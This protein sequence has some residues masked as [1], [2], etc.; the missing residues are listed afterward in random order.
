MAYVAPVKSRQTGEITSYRVRWRT[1]GARDGDPQGERFVDVDAAEVFK[2]AVDAAGQQWPPGWVKGKGLI[3][4]EDEDEARFVFEAYALE[5]IK[6]RT[7]AEDYYRGAIEK[8]LRTYILPTFANCDVRSTTHFSRRTVQGWVAT[9]KETKV[10][11]GSEHKP[12]SPKTLKNLHGLL[13]SILKEA[14]LEEPPLRLRNPCDLVDLPRT[15]DGGVADDGTDEDMCFLE[16]DEVQ[17]I[18]DELDRPTDKRLVR[19]KYATGLRWGE[20]TALP[21]RNVFRDP[22]DGKAK[23]RV[24]RAWKRKRGG[25]YYLGTPKSKRSRR[26]VRLDEVTYAEFLEDGLDEGS[27]TDL[28]HVNH[29]G[30]R[31][32]YSTFY[33]RFKVAVVRAHEAGRLPREKHPTLHDLRHSHAAALLSAGRGLTYVQRRLGHESITTTSDRYGHLLPVADDDAMATIVATLG[34]P[35]GL[36][37]E[38]D[39]EEV[40]YGFSERAAS[41]NGRRVYAV[42]MG[43]H[44]EGFWDVED[45]KAVAGQWLLDKGE[46]AL[47]EAWSAEW[48]KRSAPTGKV[49]GLRMVR[50]HVPERLQLW[51]VGPAMY[52]AD[53]TERVVRPEDHE[54]R[55]V[56][57]WEW[58]EP[59]TD[60]AAE[61]RVE[62]LPSGETVASVWGL[63][64]ETALG[65]YAQARSDALRVCGMNPALSERDSVET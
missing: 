44:L 12:M 27:P 39:S 45:A 52:S 9:M 64:R 4:H 40:P 65:A 7:G 38:V 50:S 54:P 30:Q 28:I 17:A 5:S 58:E 26:T 3:A 25:G 48:W 21:K 57:T 14:T 18:V 11:R 43:G 15:D 2:D 42:H 29:M 61:H 6:N 46:A 56:W 10:W 31:L 22:K 32:P 8:E 23:L 53:G 49:G 51:F 1:G 62:W 20:L 34:G 36:T 33:D 60:A 24:T 59:F 55:A 19:R 16:P 63:H 47:V 35:T 13:S 41:E 37:M